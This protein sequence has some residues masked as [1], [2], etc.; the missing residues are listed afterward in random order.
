MWNDFFSSPT[1]DL[2]NG[3]QHRA[4]YMNSTSETRAVN[5]CLLYLEER[6]HIFCMRESSVSTKGDTSCVRV[7]PLS[8]RRRCVLAMRVSSVSTKGDMCCGTH[9]SSISTKGSTYGAHR[10]V[11]VTTFYAARYIVGVLVTG[12]PCV[13]HYSL[14]IFVQ[15]DN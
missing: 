7:S 12:V 11:L 4:R 10:S 9:V 13:A 5:L 2:G 8:R 1:R 3:R 6:R 15:K 14:I